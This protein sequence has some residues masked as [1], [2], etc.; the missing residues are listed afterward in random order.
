LQSGG[1][2]VLLTTMNSYALWGGP[3]VGKITAVVGES[4][5]ADKAIVQGPG[6]RTFNDLRG[7]AVAYSDGSVS[8]YL[9]YYLLRVGGVSVGEVTRFGQEN[10]NQAARRY[11]A[12]EAHAVIGWTSRDLAEAARRP[13]SRVLMTSDQ[14]RVT[15]DVIVSGS[16][17]LREKREALQAFHEAWFEATKLTIE[18]PD[19]AARAMAQW[20][21]RW[22][23]VGSSH[24][25]RD[26]LAEFAQATL[27]DNEVVMA[28]EGLPILYERYQGA[29]AVW[30]SG[31]RQV[32]HP[33]READLPAVFDPA[34]VRQAAARPALISTRPPVNPT[35][36]LTA[37]PEVKGLTAE[38]Q[39][40]LIPMA[41]LG[42]DRV[43][44]AA[45]SA[46]LSEESRQVITEAVVPVLR[47]TVGTY[48]RVEGS[49]GWPAGQGLD[50]A[51]INVLAFERA[52]AVRDF[53]IKYGIPVERVVM[54]TVIPQCRECRDQAVV[55]RD[56]G[57]RLSLAAR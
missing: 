2:D 30:R 50:E 26:A 52:R 14:F 18:Q 29:Q 46:T 35:F 11:L 13:D 55:E 37:H 22:T 39:Q 51:R 33:L 32:R 16:R 57:A 1:F 56:N 3:E 4:A 25:L 23:G 45:G 9:L 38:E 7:T 17:A 42:T 15:A 24:D 21:S 31:G 36:H 47:D 6:I 40:R 20:S 43:R 34:F 5:G 12:N 8:E 49:A 41:V 48:L 54:G 27:Q 44:F 10:L 19:R 53:V 28:E